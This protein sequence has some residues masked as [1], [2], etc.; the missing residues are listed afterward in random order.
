MTKNTVIMNETEFLDSFFLLHSV[1]SKPFCED[2]K[3]KEQ[4]FPLQ[5]VPSCYIYS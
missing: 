5:L 2:Y 3:H 4:P 1:L